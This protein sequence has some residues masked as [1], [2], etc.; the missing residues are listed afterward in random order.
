[1]RDF[2]NFA[3]GIKEKI[4]RLD[5]EKDFMDFTFQIIELL[6][7]Q[8]TPGLSKFSSLDTSYFFQK[9]NL[10]RLKKLSPDFLTTLKID[11]GQTD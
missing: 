10:E 5:L 7:G 6:R 9:D 3:L 8:E 4:L 2:C 1:M 11:F